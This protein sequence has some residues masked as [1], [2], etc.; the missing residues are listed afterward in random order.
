MALINSNI[1]MFNYELKHIKGEANC[2]AD[3][4]SRLPTWLVGKDKKSDSNQDPILT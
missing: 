3:C 2:I 1:M 4:L